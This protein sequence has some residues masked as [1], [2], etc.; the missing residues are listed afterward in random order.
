MKRDT[1]FVPR[2][3]GEVP[4]WLWLIRRFGVGEDTPIYALC[5]LALHQLLGWPAYLLFY[6][7]GSS[8]YRVKGVWSYVC[9]SHFDPLA[10]IFTTSEQPF[11]FLSTIGVSSA[12][13]CL[14]LLARYLGSGEV[15]L[16]YGVPYLWVNNWLVAV[17]YL[18]HNDPGVSH[19]EGS[20]WTYLDGAISTVDRPFGLIGRHL[21]HG[22]VLSDTYREPLPGR[23][24]L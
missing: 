6:A 4:G 16:L 9:R 21:F 15:F 12:I 24:T 14:V 11:V 7:S 13:A 3:E 20:S 23:W 2:R 18:H 5:S 8:S 19:F 1:A 22:I 17:T 10:N